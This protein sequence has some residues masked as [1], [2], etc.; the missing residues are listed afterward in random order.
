MLFKR[1]QVCTGVLITLGGMLVVAAAPT[2]A[3]TTERIEITGSAIKRSISDE[4][5]LP[6]TVL[7]AED[8]RQSGVTSVESVIQLL[9]ASQSSSV[10]SNAIGSGTG[11]AAF[12]NLRGLG[13]NK[14]LVLLN[15]R[16]V[17]AFA[18]GVNAVD[19]NAIPFAVIE[20]IEVLRD[21]ASA[22]YGTDAIGGVINFITKSNYGGGSV[23]LEASRPTGQGGDKSRVSFVAGFGDLTTD[24]FNVWLS[25]D[26]QKT[27]RLRALDRRF[28]ASGIIP[29]RGV[30]GNSG[31]TFP[32]NFSQA[33]TGISA[34][35]TAPTCAPPL[36]LPNPLNPAA[37][38]FD[39][40]AT[41][42]V[43]PDVLQ[44]TVSA[45]LSTLMPGNHIGSLELVS[46]RNNTT[47]RVA[48]DPVTGITI[49]PSN[50]FYPT[51]Y[52]GL[53]KTKN[54]TA[55]WRM[56]PAGNR[57]N[58]S[59]SEADRLVLDVRGTL[60][61]FDYVAGAYYTTNTASDA[62]ADGYVNAP[63]VRDQVAAGNLN[64]FAAATAAQL[65]IIEQA[66]RRGTFAVAEGTTTGVDFRVSR[67]LF[68]LGGGNAAMSL[69][70]EARREG[71]LYNTDD[72]VVNAIPSAGRSPYHVAGDRE[73]FAVSGEMLLPLTKSL[74][75]Q[76]A[77]R[78]DHY[79]DAG[80]SVNPK[81]GMRFQPVKAFLMR[82]SYN[83]GFRAPALDDLYGPQAITFAA[84][85]VNDPLLC[86]GGKVDVAA[87]GITSRDCGQQVQVQNGG[88]PALKPEK[89]KTFSVGM[90]LEPVQGLTLSA[91]Y[92]DIRLR[93][94]VNSIDQISVLANPVLYGDKIIRCKTLPTAAQAN[95]SRCQADFVNSNAIAYV[96][97]LTDNLG[98]VNTSGVDLSAGY[99]IN[100][101]G[102]GNFDFRWDGTW[103]RSYKYQNSPTD[104]LKENVGAYV[105]SSPVFRWQHTVAAVWS[106]GDLKARL[107]VRHK[108]GYTDQNSPTT[109]VGGPSFYQ[110]VSSYTLVDLTLTSKV[111]K[112]LTVTAG[113]TNLFN[114]NPPFS[115]QSTRSQRGY[116]PRFTDPVGRALFL[117]GTLSF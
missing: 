67:E 42:D 82:A 3:Q 23:S 78:A 56:I 71:Y 12:A 22:I 5:A 114:T 36:S 117:R 8:L 91:D 77:V 6:I 27:Q 102:L 54:V 25:V 83:T 101:G 68:A 43:L 99:S 14:T 30:N 29:S 84:G 95:L 52:P 85:A 45:R 40:S 80:S 93:D 60:G 88:N 106:R 73:V 61:G 112:V 103:V 87:G 9:A 7:K 1:T 97:T 34:N 70:A 115:N 58:D 20:R 48:P 37:C 92:W 44:D 76:L 98:R 10:G 2:L 104:P 53:D 51:S 74:E 59:N 17:A 109:V 111:T 79:S 15:G 49:T 16:R 50:P 96:V 116:D 31:T 86:P 13:A 47:A 108:T 113:V 39:F 89:S 90:A 26:G 105:D 100:G 32:G 110:N 18:F 69:G 94:Q 19:L 28:S 11:G 35:L 46:T 107:G 63:F 75:M 65:A 21:G 4:G 38:V 81:I 64:P 66:K 62:A 55:G 24:N 33:A 41:I 72:A 57:T